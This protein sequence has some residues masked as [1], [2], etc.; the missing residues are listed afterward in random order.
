[1]QKYTTRKVVQLELGI[2]KQNQL[3]ND[4][5]D[6][7][8]P[9]QTWSCIT[10]HQSDE[11][12]INPAAQERSID[13]VGDIT[14]T[15]SQL[16]SA[17]PDSALLKY[18]TKKNF[19]GIDYE[20]LVKQTEVSQVFCYEVYSQGG[21]REPLSNKKPRPYKEQIRLFAKK[22]KE[23]DHIIVGGGSGL[24]A[25]GG[26]DFYYTDTPSFYKYFG[27]FAKKYG[28]KGV[29]A[30]MQHHWA[31][32][33]E[34]WGYLATFLYTTQ[35]APL[36]SP[37]QDLQKILNGKDYFILTTNQDMQAIKA[38]PEDKVA[39]IQGDARCL[40]CSRQCTDAVWD[41]VKPVEQMF[42]A[43]GDGTTV[44]TGLIPRCPYCGAEAFPWIQGYGNFLE[45]SKYHEEY[46]KITHY[47]KETM[48]DGQ[49]LFLE[50][51]VGRL[52]PTFIQEPF[53]ALTAQLPNAYDI[54]V[55]R[56]YQFLPKK[57]KD[58][59]IAVKADLAQVLNDV[60]QELQK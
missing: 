58:K 36:Y 45:A 9:L 3:V 46:G 17:K 47:L 10:L 50:L 24:S 37:Y 42:K 18:L 53:W 60:V 30:G 7:F 5:I 48:H 39:E 12:L 25:A 49:T 19:V 57:I 51:G 15:L 40:Q 14:E 55:N 29:L 59:G 56:D 20:Q 52:A 54:A 21:T 26:G 28:F 32:R 35:H 11:V 44:P 6:L 16:V 13:L 41:A 31:S 34:F 1:L 27:K 2:N 23:A 4:L 22:I 8:K 43:M 33:E 38:F